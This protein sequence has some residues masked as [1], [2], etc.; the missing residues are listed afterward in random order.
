MLKRVFYPFPQLVIALATLAAGTILDG[1]VFVQMMGFLDYALVGD[2]AS[3][4]AALPAFFIKAFLL[5]P[6]QVLGNITKSWFRMDA[7][8]S[9]KKFY[10]R[11]IFKKNISEFQQENT[12]TYLSR[13]TNDANTL[14]MNFIE[15]IFSIFS[16]VTNFGVAVWILST[17]G[18][19]MVSF[20]IKITLATALVSMLLSKPVSKKV[21]ER[22]DK[23]D[24]Y[25]SYIKEV[26]S[27]FHIVKSN[28]LRD[29]VTKD[30]EE[31]SYEIQHKG[32]IIEK[33]STFINAMQNG[34]FMIM[35]YLGLCYL[36]YLAINGDITA[37][38]ALTVSQGV[39]RLAWPLMMMSEALPKIFASKDLGKKIDESL[40][41]Q[42]QH[43]ETL[44]LTNFTDSIRLEDVG[45]AYEDADK[46]AMTL[47]HVNMEIKKNGKYLI[48]GPSGGG[49]ST[50]LK[51]L[52]KYYQPTKGT[53]LLD[54]MPLSDIKKEDYFSL[55][56]NVEQ[57]VFIFEDTLRNNLTLYKDYSKEEIDAAI[58]AAGLDSF[59]EGLRDGLDTM[60][61]ENGKNVSGGERSRIVIARAML[62]K[63][64]ILFMDEAFAALDLERA[65]EIEQ[66]ILNLKD[67][68]VINVSHV[69]FKDTK[70]QYDRIFHVKGTVA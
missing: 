49:K 56:A 7:N 34:A 23:F 40:K 61:Y 18:P 57:Q 3:L 44:T 13:L 27:A 69:I 29:K 20:S 66:T 41:N 35:I 52:R 48:V 26:L 55:I 64:D 12:A 16:G 24:G 42:N 30:Y 54:G 4:K 5:I 51:L 9:M 68:T 21:K 14:D 2:M 19:G 6:V 10:I 25:T 50:L 1:M 47:E 43:E 33:M 37:A 70:G 58:H 46:K 28:N 32:Y 65:R 67:I 60:I 63:A 59:V 62:A 39:Q 8:L 17:V 45:F 31:K 36:T 11:G 22:S 15:G 53:I 38:G